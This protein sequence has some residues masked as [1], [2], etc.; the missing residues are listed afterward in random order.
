MSSV[1]ILNALWHSLTG[2]A[3]ILALLNLPPSATVD[4]KASKVQREREPNGLATTNIPLICIYPQEGLPSRLNSMVYDAEV[5]VD[6]YAS[7]L[8]QCMTIGKLIQK[9]W[10]GQLPN[11]TSGQSFELEFM[12]EFGGEAKINGIKKYSQRWCLGDVIWR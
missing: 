6:I 12:G 7:N 11:V 10:N 3:E 4:Q 2:S 1:D 9:L 8:F 5:Q